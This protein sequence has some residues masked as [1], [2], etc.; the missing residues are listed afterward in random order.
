MSHVCY[1]AA[2]PLYIPFPIDFW[3]VH[4]GDFLKRVI[5]SVG[6][7]YILAYS[8][9]LFFQAIFIFILYVCLQKSLA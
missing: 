6:K 8:H 3:L 2:S 7:P 4:I 5:F 9:W 1:G